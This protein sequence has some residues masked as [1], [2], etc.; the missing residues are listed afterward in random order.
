M[1]HFFQENQ[2]GER[3]LVTINRSDFTN[4]SSQHRFS[5]ES[6]MDFSDKNRLYIVVGSDSGLLIQYLLRHA[7]G[8]GSRVVV[9]ELDNVHDLISKATSAQLKKLNTK[10]GFPRVSLHRQSLWQAE[11]LDG[12]EHDWLANESVSLVASI[13][14]ANDPVH[15]YFSLLAEARR[16]MA[17]RQ[18]QFR[19]HKGVRKYTSNQI[20]NSTGNLHP[21]MLSKTFGENRCAIVLGNDEPSKSHLDFAAQNADKLFIVALPEICQELARR[22]LRPDVV[23][24]NEHQTHSELTEHFCRRWQDVLLIHP[25]YTSPDTLQLWP[26]PRRFLGD[27]LPWLDITAFD[28]DTQALLEGPMSCNIAVSVC[29]SMGFSQIILGGV[30]FTTAT[31][32]DNAAETYRLNLPQTAEARMVNYT[33]QWISA[34]QEQRCSLETMETLAARV[35]TS[36]QRITNLSQSAAA[37]PSIEYIDKASLCLSGEKPD[38]IQLLSQDRNQPEAQPPA[39]KDKPQASLTAYRGIRKYARE[40]LKLI[41]KAASEPTVDNFQRTSRQLLKL[42]RRLSDASRRYI[43]TAERTSGFEKPRLYN[44][45]ATH[46]IRTL[47]E[48]QIIHTYYASLDHFAADFIRAINALETLTQA[49]EKTHNKF[50]D[51]VETQGG[52]CDVTKARGDSQRNLRNW[53]NTVFHLFNQQDRAELKTL[54][55]ILDRKQW[56]YPT[57]REFTA[58]LINELGKRSANAYAHYQ[59]VINQC[60]HS[61]KQGRNLSHDTETMLEE[62]LIRQAGL[63]PFLDTPSDALENLQSLSDCLPHFTVDYARA[64]VSCGQSSVAHSVLKAHLEQY[65]EDRQARLLL[66]GL[67][68]EII[69]A[70]E[71]SPAYQGTIKGALGA[72][73]DGSTS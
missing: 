24:N 60:V 14:C 6:R 35:K 62:A 20:R 37:S 1:S 3:Y 40:A 45:L 65:S 61:A 10:S 38:V 46:D 26:G 8:E 72:I 39:A 69:A 71:H 21:L 28:T 23:V 34:S 49:E 68:A 11:V 22:G 47:E 9:I 66:H 17:E 13:A 54:H 19:I 36:G 4:V 58:G 30:H 31:A 27:R 29:A 70:R 5:Q 48:L 15:E 56:L 53:L 43:R 2:W 18:L 33:G 64:L 41:Q 7:P 55:T 42:E 73:M 25:F 12:A 63:F 50:T 52:I 44:Y 51:T 57:L 59:N 32:G 67:Q 16:V